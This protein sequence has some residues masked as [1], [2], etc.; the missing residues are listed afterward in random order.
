MEELGKL[1]SLNIWISV[2]GFS[3]LAACLVYIARIYS[4]A[5]ASTQRIADSMECIVRMIDR[6]LQ[7]SKS[8]L[9]GQ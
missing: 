1:V 9:R 5:C 7:E 8:L 6:D 2:L 3:F 4:E